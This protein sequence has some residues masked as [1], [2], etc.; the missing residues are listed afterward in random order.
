M[1]VVWIFYNLISLQT[2][3]SHR[4]LIQTQT[5]TV[6][7]I[8][9]LILVRALGRDLSTVSSILKNLAAIL[10]SLAAMWRVPA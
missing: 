9:E 6:L 3:K 8:K 1:I 7:Q 2:I 10:T 5:V 4:T